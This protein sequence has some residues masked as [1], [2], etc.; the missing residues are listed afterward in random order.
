MFIVKDVSD[1]TISS[2]QDCLTSQVFRR[3]QKIVSDSADSSLPGFSRVFQGWVS[4]GRKP[5]D[6]RFK[7]LKPKA[8]TTTWYEDCRCYD[9][10]YY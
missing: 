9:Q 5:A 6:I 10:S 2:W 7:K 1:K 8:V 3:W 4:A